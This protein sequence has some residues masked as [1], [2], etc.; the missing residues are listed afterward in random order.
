M[1]ACITIFPVFPV[2]QSP[3]FVKG[4]REAFSQMTSKYSR[5]EELLDPIQVDDVID[6]LIQS[7][8]STSS[9]NTHIVSVTSAGTVQVPRANARP[10]Q[11]TPA[12]RGAASDMLRSVAQTVDASAVARQQ[13]QMLMN[14]Q[15]Y[16]ALM[17]CI[18]LHELPK[19]V[20]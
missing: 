12:T 7:G 18:C 20:H 9:A 19:Q 3:L 4:I 17:C 6:I 11:Q 10:Q 13:Q 1:K 15:V 5:L 2:S 16:D 14:R 8:S